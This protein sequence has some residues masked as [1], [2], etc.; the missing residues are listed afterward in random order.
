L[1]SVGF[2]H[3]QNY[4]TL[5]PTIYAKADNGKIIINWTSEAENSVDTLTGYRDFEGYRIYKSTDGGETWGGPDDRIYFNGEARGWIPLVQFDLTAEEDSLFCLKD[6]DCD[7]EEDFTRGMGISGI[8]PLA[9]WVNLGTDTGLEYTFIDSNVYNGKEYT[10]A[11]VSYDIGL[12]TY[13]LSYVPEADN[14][15]LC[16]ATDSTESM[17]NET[18]CCGANGGEWDTEL[19]RC[20]YEDCDLCNWEQLFDQVE[21][22]DVTNPDQFAD[23]D[24]N[25]YA[26]IECAITEN[27]TVT[28][29]PGF[30]AE[31]V[32]NISFEGVENADGIILQAEF[33]TVGNGMKS[34]VIVNEDDLSESVYRFEIQ[35]AYLVDSQGDT[36]DVYEGYATGNPSLYVYEIIS[37]ENISPLNYTPYELIEENF[38]DIITDLGFGFPSE[39]NPA[40]GAL[41]N[42]DECILLLN[43][44]ILDFPGAILT[45]DSEYRIPEYKFE[46]FELEYIDDLGYASNFT[47]FIDGLKFRFDNSLR[48]IPGTGAAALNILKYITTNE[49][50]ERDTTLFETAPFFYIGLNY[51]SNGGAFN[52]RPPYSY[53]IKFSDTPM[54][55]A[56]KTVP[57]SGCSDNPGYALLPFEIT[58]LTTGKV[59]GVYHTDKGTRYEKQ[60]DNCDICGSTQWC[61]NGVCTELV[62]D[63][64]CFWEK[65]EMIAFKKDTVS[66]LSEIDTDEY[67]FDLDINFI[68]F[69]GA[70][71]DSSV[72]YIAGEYVKRSDM[73]WEAT[74]EIAPGTE[75]SS[76]IDI[77]DDGVND[78]PWKPLYGWFDDD[79]IIIEPTRWYVDGDA[80]IADF[81]EIGRKTDIDE[82][83]LDNISVVPNPYFVHSK[84]DET[85]NSRLMWFTHLPTF[86]Y[87]NIYTVSGE[88]VKS[89]VHDDNFS[90]QESWDLRTGIGDE[91]A[92]GLY[93]YTVE[94]G[95]NEQ[96][97]HIGKFAIVR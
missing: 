27:N 5:I 32:E 73:T 70:P 59:V 7:I 52:K 36:I 80:W 87:I 94:A 24:G 10:Y 74:T 51:G 45:Q 38:S 31:N 76:W 49:V 35:A 82:D 69:G 3:A 37:S 21:D 67:T 65:G 2:I 50:G 23:A 14:M 33:Q 89:F 86:C 43:D 60:D 61:N 1:N 6:L 55:E 8:D 40:L 85:E 97:K 83:D 84:F 93:I 15:G 72:T 62:G 48:S 78:N 57:S 42:V 22:W 18:D 88:L 58:N 56:V 26:S 12:R 92:P 19:D 95:N 47:D 25:G 39:C 81:G 11:V 71:Y 64:D 41:Y 46:N 20:A 29:I 30:Y 68:L 9:P 13:E 63:K 28:A 16:T 34:F 66:T 17:L 77:N 91:V 79:E 54:Y 90:G 96:F 75:P 44:L 4:T 53:R